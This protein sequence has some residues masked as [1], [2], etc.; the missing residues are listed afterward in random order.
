MGARNHKHK[1][2]S[3]TLAIVNPAAKDSL[4]TSKKLRLET[5]SVEGVDGLVIVGFDLTCETHAY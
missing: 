3:G 4:H 1:H 2:L 5:H